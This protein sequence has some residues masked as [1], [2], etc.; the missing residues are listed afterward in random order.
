MRQISLTL[1]VSATL[2]CPIAYA[3]IT[4]LKMTVNSASKAFQTSPVNSNALVEAAKI[5]AEYQQKQLNKDHSMQLSSAINQQATLAQQVFL[6][7]K[8]QSPIVE[9]ARKEMQHQLQQL[10]KDTANTP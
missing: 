8:E 10:Q 7:S 4:E 2:A 1:L 9:K 3:D 5:E 6:N